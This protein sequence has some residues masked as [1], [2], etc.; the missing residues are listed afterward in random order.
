MESC[1]AVVEEV[2]NK[3]ARLDGRINSTLKSRKEK[4]STAEYRSMTTYSGYAKISRA[5]YFSKLER[6][7]NN[8]D[9]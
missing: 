3:H 4:V 5:G 8:P 6:V 2:T 1:I 9:L 7:K